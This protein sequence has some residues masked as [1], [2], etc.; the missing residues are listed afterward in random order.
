M[1][2]LDNYRDIHAVLKEQAEQYPDKIY[3]ISPDQDGKKITFEQTLEW[4]NRIANFLRQEGVKPSDTVSM[5]AQNSMETLLI[6]F[7]V[8][9]YGAIVNP[10]N[11]E[12]SQENVYRLLNRAKP[13]IV[14]FGREMTFDRTR[15]ADGMWIAFS[16]DFIGEQK[17]ET[18]FSTVLRSYS[19]VFD[20]PM[21]DKD[22]YSTITF[23]SGTTATP[24]AIASSRESIYLMAVE[25]IDRFRY[26]DKD[27]I[28]DYRA[29]NWNSPQILSIFSSL[30]CGASLVYAR[31]FS[32]SR[33]ASWLKD[34]GVTVC[35]G[36][37]TVI[38]F[39]LEQPVPLH[40]KDVP[41]LRFMSSSSAPLLARNLLEFEKRYGIPINQLA[42]STET[43]VMAMN[44]PE[45]LKNP[46]RRIGSIGKVVK[47]KEVFV[48]DEHGNRL[49]PGEE[50]EIVVRGRSMTLGYITENGRLDR[51][52]EEGFHTGDIGYIDSEGFV[53]ITGRLKNQVVR[54][55]VKISPA[56][57]TNR[58]ME[59]PAVQVAETI[60]V[61]DKIYGEDVV[62]FILPREGTQITT[63]EIMAHCK[64]K[65]PDFKM[66]KAIFF[67]K[68]FPTGAT[69]KISKVGLLKIWEEE[70]GKSAEG[71]V[72]SFTGERQKNRG[73]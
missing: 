48:V 9:N 46:E 52:P 31:S 8:L 20:Q 35:I 63:E 30:I 50:G 43:N 58:I 39:L 71:G 54:G 51:F 17:P 72:I 65:L 13:K 14:F 57:I 36:V 4:C 70:L 55:G 49:K 44:D 56:E 1:E 26:T 60:G 37:P 28:L 47:F 61:P 73:G 25:T 19:P 33:W 68:E 29:Y 45:D 11:V 34:Y 3:L 27:V 23:T 6:F 5:I 10:I 41:V 59:H 64:K 66:P 22:G 69:G 32:R 40:K 16:A 7:G 21:L 67:V 12:E 24:K 15:Y 2:N 62:S 18:E 38:N 53:Y 42:G